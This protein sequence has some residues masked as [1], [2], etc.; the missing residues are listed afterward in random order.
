MGSFVAV[1]SEKALQTDKPYVNSW[2]LM[3]VIILISFFKEINV[4]SGE[5][6]SHF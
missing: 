3:D 2:N 5:Q 1:S 4:Y 6:K